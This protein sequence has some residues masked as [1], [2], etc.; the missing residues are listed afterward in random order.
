MKDIKRWLPGVL[1]S[2]LA[3][4]AIFYFVDFERLV[5]AVRQADYTLLS[6][7]FILGS[8]WLMLRAL[9]WRTILQ[10][11]ASYSMTFWT[12]SEGVDGRIGIVAVDAGVGAGRDVAD[13]VAIVVV[14]R[15]GGDTGGVHAVGQRVAIIIH[16]VA[17]AG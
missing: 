3:I 1:I 8:G 15:A 9:V 10:E 12:A 16:A 14:I 6:I 5:E 11:K 7:A 2:V 4:A 17:T 13:T